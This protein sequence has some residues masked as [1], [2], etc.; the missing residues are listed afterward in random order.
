MILL[1]NTADPNNTEII[2]DNGIDFFSHQFKTEFHQSEKLLK[3]IDLFLR[4]R[5]ITLQDLKGIVTVLG[6]GPF[7]SLRIGV[8][9]T[10]TLGYALNIKTAGLKK[11]EFSS[12]KELV[13]KGREK[14]KSAKSFKIL[15]PFYGKKPNITVARK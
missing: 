7:T 11:Q 8:V 2:L 5:K 1:I 15:E 13:E 14:I 3:E 6:P 9:V 4:K 12:V 10:N